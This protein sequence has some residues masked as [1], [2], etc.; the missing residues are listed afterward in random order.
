MCDIVGQFASELFLR[1]AEYTGHFKENLTDFFPF[2]KLAFIE[3]LKQ[4]KGPVFLGIDSNR[5]VSQIQEHAR[6]VNIFIYHKEIIDEFGLDWILWKEH[7]PLITIENQFYA[8]E[9]NGRE[10]NR[11]CEE[12]WCT[13]KVNWTIWDWWNVSFLRITL[14]CQPTFF[15]N[16]F[17]FTRLVFYL[18]ILLPAQIEL[19]LT[20]WPSEFFISSASSPSPN[21]A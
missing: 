1:M 10:G 11:F 8:K 19:I 7:H 9:K 18:Y 6:R 2:A 12:L 15:P 5:K 21:K 3:V 13:S 16:T 14:N 20:G 4:S 17:R